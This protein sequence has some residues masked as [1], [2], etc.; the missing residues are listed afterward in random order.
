MRV[1]AGLR[2]GP[3]AQP[4][5]GQQDDPL[6]IRKMAAAGLGERVRNVCSSTSPVSPTGIV[7]MT[8]SQASRSVDVSTLRVRGV[9]PKA[10]TI[11]IQSLRKNTS[12]AIAVATW[13]ATMNAR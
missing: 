9:Q 4:F 6:T 8:I 13:S 12:S 11:A 7:A 1:D 3:A 10:L 5:A 2:L